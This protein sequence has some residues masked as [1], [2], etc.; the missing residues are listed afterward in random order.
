MKRRRERGIPSGGGLGRDGRG[1]GAAT[2]STSSPS[3]LR[4]EGVVRVGVYTST[5]HS[6]DV[7]GGRR[8]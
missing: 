6:D 4:R 1:I 5:T 3:L 2:S 8:V 7:L